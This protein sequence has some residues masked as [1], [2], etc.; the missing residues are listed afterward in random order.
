MRKVVV[1]APLVAAAATLATAALAGPYIGAASKT[2]A[3][4]GEVMHCPD[5]DSRQRTRFE[6]FSEYAAA[7]ILPD[8][9]RPLNQVPEFRP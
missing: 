5:P 6:Q 4:T 7:P 8:L 1:F 9:V 2:R 3:S